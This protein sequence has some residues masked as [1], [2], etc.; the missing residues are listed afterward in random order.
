MASTFSAFVQRSI[1]GVRVESERLR[2]IEP[3]KIHFQDVI[4]V[5]IRAW[6]YLYPMRWHALAYIGLAVFQF[7]FDTFFAFTYFGLIFNNIIL[8]LPVSAIGAAMLSL[9]PAHRI[10]R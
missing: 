7:L 5:F 6:P 8:N 4:A 9:D 10:H 1:H 2:E 3:D